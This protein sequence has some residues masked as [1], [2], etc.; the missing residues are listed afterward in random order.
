M[1]KS[2]GNFFTIDEVLRKFDGETL[3][4]FMLRTHY[5]SPFNFADSL[6]DD[7]RAAL[8]RLYT[9]L[10][11]VPAEAVPVDWTEPRAAAF[12]AAMDD[13]FNTPAALAVLFE[14]ASDLNRT[15]D[16][17][18]AVLLKSLGAVLGVL[19][20]APR[21]YLQGGSGPDE[22]A[23]AGLIAERASAKAAR[24]FAE[25]DRIRAELAAQGIELKDSA[26]GTTWVRA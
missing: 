7:A 15:R 9:A 8:R 19:Q 16:V 18:T 3:R 12:K 10:E 14:L 23:I 26:Q 11:A 2:L 1:S 25:A 5:R 13:D 4:F 20:Q 6:I 24:N 22:S 17:G 21:A